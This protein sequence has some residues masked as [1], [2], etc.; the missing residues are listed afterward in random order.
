MSQCMFARGWGWVRLRWNSNNLEIVRFFGVGK[1]LY[2]PPS[3][4][5]VVFILYSAE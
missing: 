4:E 1:W 2:E 5:L 3:S